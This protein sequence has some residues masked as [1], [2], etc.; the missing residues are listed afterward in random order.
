MCRDQELVAEDPRYDWIFIIEYF[1]SPPH[2]NTPLYHPVLSTMPF[3][4]RSHGIHRNQHS[5]DHVKPFSQLNSLH[6]YPAGDPTVLQN[7]YWK[8]NTVTVDARL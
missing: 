6:S 8:I 3:L 4:A 1:L 7:G 5:M 2:V